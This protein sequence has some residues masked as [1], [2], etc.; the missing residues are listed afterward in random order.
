MTANPGTLLSEIRNCTV[1][2]NHL[3]LPPRPIVQIDPAAKILLAGQAPGRK[4]HEQGRPFDDAS[5]D[6]LRQ[7]LAVDKTT[8]YDPQ[9]FAIVPMGF[10]F[11]GS[12]PSGDLPPRPECAETWHARIWQTLNTVQLTLVIGQYAMQH[13]LSTHE[14]GRSATRLSV[15][16]HVQQW[17]CYLP[18]YLPLP[19]PSPRNNRW[20]RNNPW[21]E[22]TLLP[23]L[24][25]R[26]AAIL[27]R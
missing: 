4:T 9:Q 12:G 22:Q 17:Q 16:Q 14:K 27:E 21:F 26:V 13:H 5:G 10:C 11:P 8:F 3:P 20:L 7:W 15:T 25:R 24:R 6:R 19:H 23:D 2:A 1:C 18:D